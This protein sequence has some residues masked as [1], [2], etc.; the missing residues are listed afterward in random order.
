MREITP[1]LVESLSPGGELC[2]IYLGG[3]Q[4]EPRSL[5]ARESAAAPPRIPDNRARSNQG[6][7]RLQLSYLNTH[8]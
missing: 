3:F 5:P 7:H 6:L 8:R 2:D 4:W 1:E